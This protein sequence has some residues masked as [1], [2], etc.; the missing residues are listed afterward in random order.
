M[1]SELTI[2]MIVIDDGGY[3]SI[4]ANSRDKS[5][6]GHTIADIDSIDYTALTIYG[7]LL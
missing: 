6:N 2:V 3:N 7:S 5:N 1:I 4:G